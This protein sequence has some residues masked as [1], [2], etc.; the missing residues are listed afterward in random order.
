MA[1]KAQAQIEAPQIEG[2]DDYRAYLADRVAW[3]KQ[4]NPKFS[5]RF[6]ARKAGF[7]S[8]AFLKH[9]IDGSRNLT[10]ASISRFARGLDLSEEETEVFEILVLFSQAK[11][12]RERNR[13]FQRLRKRKSRHGAIA[14]LSE[15]QYDIYSEWYVLA[16]RELLFLPE[17]REDPAWI[18]AR[19]FP[20]ISEEEAA[21]A[22]ELLEQVG[23]IARDGND[24]L[25]PAKVTISTPLQVGSLAVRNY[26]RAMLD[27]AK[28][29]LDAL[30]PSERNVTSLTFTAGRADYEELCRKI[31]NFQE[32][33]LA[34]VNRGAED[35]KKRTPR[36]PEEVL[37][38]GFQLVPLTR[39]PED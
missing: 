7:K 24:R 14:E 29:S 25:R 5:Y 15:A 4:S 33:V 32:E 38:L 13:H 2:Y 26:H 20:R 8:P 35:N 27:N 34:F 19:V 22:L 18:A 9:V 36:E 30:A 3:L 6:F 10:A 28:H 1:E 23:L 21:R 16:I 12:D 31:A 11:D 39:A 37:L 17:F